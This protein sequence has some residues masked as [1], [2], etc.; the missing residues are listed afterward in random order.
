MC[1]IALKH[2]KHAN[3]ISIYPK[4]AKGDMYRWCG[5]HTENTMD[6]T[7]QMNMDIDEYASDVVV[8]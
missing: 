3:I 7:I 6:Y 1:A 4:L 5:S 8:L 2:P